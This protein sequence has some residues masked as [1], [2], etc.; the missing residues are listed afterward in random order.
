[1]AR[2][3][4]LVVSP[5]LVQRLAGLEVDVELIGPDLLATGLPPDV[6]ARVEAVACM[7][8]LDDALVDAL[9]HLRLVACFSTGYEGIDL[10]RLQARGIALTTGSGVNA[11]DVA[12]HAVALFL[13][14]RHDVVRQDH[15]VRSGRWRGDAP[16]RRSLRGQRAGLVGFGR[17]GQ[18]IAARMAAHQMA[19]AWWGPN[20]KADA[21][22][23]RA[24]SLLDL[25]HRSDVLF[26]TS[27]STP[28]NKGQIDGH[29][30][31]ALGPAGYL[32]NVARGSLVD[33]SA[34]IAA[35]RE[36]AIAGAGLD[37]FAAEPADPVRW[38][39]LPNLLLSPHVAG[40]TA[41]GGEALEGLLRANVERWFRGEPLL[42]PVERLSAK[43]MP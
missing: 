38:R 28:D 18:A 8:T 40:F 26:V 4:L 33:E 24:E 9:P 19:I 7:G 29:V 37:V 27:R 31:Q 14:L 2:R 5:F 35:L 10:A 39:D 21:V 1:M 32:I 11:H 42:T 13:G 12:D 6:A 20:P 41:E 30:L 3:A 16:P 36:G 22:Y 25:A 34:L 17:I 43:P 23:P 15:L